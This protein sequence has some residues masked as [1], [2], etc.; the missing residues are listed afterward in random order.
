MGLWFVK[1]LLNK[2]KPCYEDNIIILFCAK[3]I[4]SP[5]AHYPDSRITKK[6]VK[7]KSKNI[8]GCGCLLLISVCRFPL[9]SLF[10]LTQCQPS[11][12]LFAEHK[13]ILSK[14]STN[15]LLGTILKMWNKI[16]FSKEKK[17]FVL[18]IKFW[19]AVILKTL[20]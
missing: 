19:K 9:H 3:P 5:M 16:S 20:S 18:S 6:I 13:I 4:F 12:T 1:K 2:N 8:F 11:S 14:F 10:G 15:I 7:A 17:W